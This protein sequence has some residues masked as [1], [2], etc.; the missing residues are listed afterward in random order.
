MLIS[1]VNDNLLFHFRT[2]KEISDI[3]EN[4]IILEE[5]IKFKIRLIVL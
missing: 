2:F 1:S 4:Y 3:K 5:T